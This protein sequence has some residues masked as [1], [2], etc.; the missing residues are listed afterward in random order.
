MIQKFDRKQCSLI[1]A[2][3]S[4]FPF[5]LHQQTNQTLNFLFKKIQK[6]SKKENQEEEEEAEDTNSTFSPPTKGEREKF[7]REKEGTPKR[8]KHRTTTTTTKSLCFFQDFLCG[9]LNFLSPGII[10]VKPPCVCFLILHWSN[11]I[12]LKDQSFP[13]RQSNVDF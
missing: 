12:A 3:H 9:S 5:S 13:V 4:W 8:E 2:S 6:Y 1:Y 7:V 10:F 11:P